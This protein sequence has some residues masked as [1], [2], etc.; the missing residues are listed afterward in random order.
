MHDAA[1]VT[2]PLSVATLFGVEVI[3]E[4]SEALCEAGRLWP[5][6]YE[7]ARVLAAEYPPPGGL[8]GKKVV[9]VRA[10]PRLPHPRAPS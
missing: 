5:V 6:T 7:L 9:E 4:T 3:Y 2:P 8:R 1:E 10:T